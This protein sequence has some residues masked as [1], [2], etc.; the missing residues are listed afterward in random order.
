MKNLVPVPFGWLSEPVSLP[1]FW[2]AALPSSY[3]FC[4]K[5][6]PFPKSFTAP[7]PADWINLASWTATA[8]TRPC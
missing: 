2:R 6:W 5:T 1:G 8:R 4:A 3:V 7:W